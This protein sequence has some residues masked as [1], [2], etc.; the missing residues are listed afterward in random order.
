M[1]PVITWIAG[2]AR[3]LSWPSTRMRPSSGFNSPSMSRNRVDL[4]APSGPTRP[5]MRPAAIDA[6]TP[7][8]ARLAPELL[9]P[10]SMV[11]SGSSMADSGRQG[12]GDGH[13]LAQHLIRLVH[14]HAQA[15]DEIGA[16]RGRLHR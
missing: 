15:I 5:V 11:T 13:A 9:L 4:P 2:A 14:D 3:T 12:D 7:S 10:F 8:M 1:Y 6:V 16:K